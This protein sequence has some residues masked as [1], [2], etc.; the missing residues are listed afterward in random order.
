ME[1]L[2]YPF[3]AQA[4]RR[5][6]LHHRLILGCGV[7][8]LAAVLSNGSVLG[9]NDQKTA[10]L[11]QTARSQLPLADPVVNM[12]AVLQAQR[13]I[14]WRDGSAKILL[15]ERNVSIA[16]GAYGFRAN[17]ALVRIDTE[18]RLG[19]SI[20]HLALYLDE[21]RPIHGGGA[22]EAQ[23]PRLLVTVSTF[24]QIQLVADS[25]KTNDATPNGEFIE[26]GVER[27][28][29]FL[30]MVTAKP[31]NIPAGGQLLDEDVATLR[32]N[33][34]EQ[35][36]MESMGRINR[37]REAVT[38]SHSDQRVATSSQDHPGRP[39]M[40]TTG[41]VSFYADKIVFQEGNEDNEE[42]TL[43]LVGGVRV[44]YQN[45]NRQQSMSLQSEN[46]VILLSPGAMGALGGRETAAADVRGVYLEDNVI[47]TDGE[48]TIRAPRIFYDLQRNKAVVL[49]AV[50][51]TWDVRHHLP[52]YVR[53]QKLRQESLTHWTAQRATL[54]T[55]EFAEP[56][57]SIAAGQVTI[58]RQTGSDGAANY[59]FEAADSSLRW[60]TLP[61]FY[62]PRLS[63]DLTTLQETTTP[64]VSASYSDQDGPVIRTTW[65]LFSVAG[66]PEPEGIKLRGRADILGDRGAA[67]GVNLDYT[68]PRMQ[69]QLDGYLVM[70]DTAEDEIGDRFDVAFD[71]DTRGYA[72]WRH[73]QYMRDHWDLSIEFSHVSDET[74]LEEFF[75]NEAELSKPYETSIYLKKQENDLAFTF[76]AQY[77][78]T[79]FTPQI[80]TLQSPG[81]TVEKQSELG[82]HRI[83][84]ALWGNRLTYSSETRLTR[85]R[86]RAGDNTPNDRGFTNNQSAALF[87]TPA[88]TQFD[89][90]LAAMGVPNGYRLRLD[91]RHEIQ[92]PIK[93][94]EV[95]VVPYA[96]GRATLYDDDFVEFAGEDDNTRLWTTLGFRAHTQVNKIYE[97]V[98][99][100]VLDLYRLR[101]IIEPRVDVF[102][103]GSTVNPEDIPLYDDDVEG[104]HEGFGVR[105]GGKN[106]F[107][108]QRGGPGRWRS[109]DWIVL[110][111][112]LVFR[113]DDTDVDREIAQFFSYRPEFSMGGDHFHTDLMW[114]VSDALAAVGE[115]VYSFENERVPQWRLGLSLRQGPRLSFFTDYS[116]ID[117]LSS[118]LLT[119]GFNYEL[120]RKYTVSLRHTLDLG[121]DDSRSIALSLERKLPRWRMVIE[122]RIDELDDEV[123]FG[124]VLIPEGVRS[125]RL[126]QPAGQRSGP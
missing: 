115:L 95:D 30:A 11:T 50:F 49:E 74:F 126:V 105:V 63:G 78:T 39:I 97:N 88:N 26:A 53:A 75:Q 20:H 120:T 2:R 103:S 102:W 6:S 44:M 25:L 27:I 24:G 29:R 69:G 91:T 87:G 36:A 110:G 83:G 14:S 101:H 77:D 47:A 112:D 70:H 23:A 62:W 10:D 84:T 76:L 1:L 58:R 123:T 31:L 55:S 82:Y 93:M 107:Q 79:G 99:S 32:R 28:E 114:M 42:S 41:T 100:R 66:Q 51:Y 86:A 94:G 56:H 22:V 8:V 43:V 18:N 85:M 64:R 21:A 67:T 52:I 96:T 13:S 117:L 4:Y 40:A 45:Q 38:G 72:L 92:S 59:K 9:E 37:L 16:V 54:T 46:A 3:W 98:E 80:T 106:I 7:Y 33:R 65:N 116:E 5:V 12:D 81:Y 104:L 57:F 48:Y 119:Y 61:L 118:R 35:I 73:R 125:S 111:T 113:G 60:G 17:R 34:R 90:N 121:G 89:N 19:G 124:I 68:L 15:L 108:T 109:V 71:G 122:T